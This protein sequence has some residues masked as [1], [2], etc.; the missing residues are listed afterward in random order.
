MEYARQA[1]RPFEAAVAGIAISALL[2][3]IN[4]SIQFHP[5]NRGCIFDFNRHRDSI[6]TNF[7]DPKIEDECLKKMEPKYRDAA[8]ALIKKLRGFEGA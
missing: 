1:K 6:V 3:D 7:K 8:V 2:A 4:P 5:T